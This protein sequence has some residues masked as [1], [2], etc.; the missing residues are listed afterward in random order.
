[1]RTVERLDDCVWDLY[2]LERG[3]QGRLRGKGL[4]ATLQILQSAYWIML[5]IAEAAVT[6]LAPY[7]ISVS[8]IDVREAGPLSGKRVYWPPAFNVP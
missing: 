2:Q 4:I 7:A 6:K 1:M 3:L 8:N 5:S